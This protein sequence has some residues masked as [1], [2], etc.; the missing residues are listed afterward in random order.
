LDEIG[1]LGERLSEY[2]VRFLI[3]LRSQTRDTSEYGFRCLSGLLRMETKRNFEN[4]G[5]KIE[6]CGGPKKL[7]KKSG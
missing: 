2:W 3:Y 5:R 7:D 1:E 4:V 6:V